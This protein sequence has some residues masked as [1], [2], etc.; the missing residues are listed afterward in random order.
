[1][2]EYVERLSQMLFRGP[3]DPP[4]PADPD[5]PHARPTPHWEVLSVQPTGTH[6]LLDISGT[7]GRNALPVIDKF[8][9][10]VPPWRRDPYSHWK[11]HVMR[12]SDVSETQRRRSAQ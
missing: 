6:F 11:R 12:A 5:T 9:P 3:P 10:E 7:G 8:S 2:R 4:P 1:M